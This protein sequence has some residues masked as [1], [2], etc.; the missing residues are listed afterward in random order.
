MALQ[1]VARAQLLFACAL[2][3]NGTCALVVADDGAGIAH[4]RMENEPS[5][6]GLRLVKLL[7]NQL[8]GTFTL[9]PKERGTDAVVE[10]PHPALA[11][12]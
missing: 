9:N 12:A 2:N 11:R 7:T 6:S 3:P 1:P 4:E 10:F 8:G 5:T